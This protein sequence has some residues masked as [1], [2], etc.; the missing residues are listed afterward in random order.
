MTEPAQPVWRRVLFTLISA[1]EHR[2]GDLRT[3]LA[4]IPPGRS[5]A[6]RQTMVVT[7]TVLAHAKC[8]AREMESHITAGREPED[9]WL[10]SIGRLIESCE[11]MAGCR[12]IDDAERQEL[13]LATVRPII[14]AA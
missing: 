7:E 1:L 5:S 2:I 13:P 12:L 6:E 11:A 8:V 14:V 3:V 4:A 9:S 10:E